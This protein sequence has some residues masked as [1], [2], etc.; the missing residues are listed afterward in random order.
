MPA[1]K[2]IAVA[3][4]NAS[5]KAAAKRIYGIIAA[6]AQVCLRDR[7]TSVRSRPDRIV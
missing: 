5:R 6:G 3:A 2:T 4:L 1:F 7:P